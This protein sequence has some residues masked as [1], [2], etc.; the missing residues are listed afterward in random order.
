HL[1]LALV[2][3]STPD[4]EPSPLGGVLDQG[5]L[6]GA[7]RAARRKAQAQDPGPSALDHD[8]SLE[9]APG[10]AGVEPA[11][12]AMLGAERDRLAGAAD[13][14]DLGDL[15]IEQLGQANRQLC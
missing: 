10:L 13:D 12:R 2:Q 8:R 15:G 14:L 9:G 5:A 11:R 1:M 4:P 3:L 6:G 7:E